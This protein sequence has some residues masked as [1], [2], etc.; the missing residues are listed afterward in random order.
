MGAE[1][2]VSLVRAMMT[3][4]RTIA[5]MAMVVALSGCSLP[6]AK[7]APLTSPKG[8]DGN[9]TMEVEQREKK[10]LDQVSTTT[11]DG[12]QPEVEGNDTASAALDGGPA[13]DAVAPTGHD[14]AKQADAD[15]EIENPSSNETWLASMH[16]M[17]TTGTYDGHPAA[18]VSMMGDTTMPDGGTITVTATTPTSNQ[19]M[20]LDVN[21][22]EN[23]R[24]IPPLVFEDLADTDDVTFDISYDNE[25]ATRL[26]EDYPT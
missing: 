20:R 11:T 23:P 5:A 16:V 14:S 18:R 21:K 4:A 15:M 10:N 8:H 25:T 26:T 1:A 24:D 13:T 17:L 22:I 3:H 2:P 6:W 7:D 9:V 19:E 12:P